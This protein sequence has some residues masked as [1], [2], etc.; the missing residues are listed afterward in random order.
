MFEHGIVF[1]D[2]RLGSFILPYYAIERITFHGN[3]RSSK[4]WMEVTV[5]EEGA[6]L[7]PLG[8]VAERSFFLL[9]THELTNQTILKVQKV[10]EQLE[11]E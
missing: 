4:D 8:Y 1:S 9:V 6:N 5:N 10:R 2:M 3:T 7:V 11:L